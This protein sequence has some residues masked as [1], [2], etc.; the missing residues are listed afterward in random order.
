[1]K[2]TKCDSLKY[3]DKVLSLLRTMSEPGEI[4]VY[5]WSN[6]REQGYWLVNYAADAAAVVARNRNSDEIR[7]LVGKI[8]QFDT[9]THQPDEALWEEQRRT[10][11]Y[12][13]VSEAA[14]FLSE[15]LA[16]TK[17]KEKV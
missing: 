13:N 5:A 9:T 15:H 16:G 12:E 17:V 14:R 1:M 10:C 8:G 3:A 11:C 6:G 2:I 4:T 7:V